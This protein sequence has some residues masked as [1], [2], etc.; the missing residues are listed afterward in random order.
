MNKRNDFR[1]VVWCPV[2]GIEFVKENFNQKYCS[3]ECRDKAA[4]KNK[5]NNRKKT[6]GDLSKNML[7]I[8]EMV[9]DNPDYAAAQR[10]GD[11]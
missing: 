3:K 10:R 5:N 2:C 11:K 8:M 6:Y 7:K 4:A 1:K 9:R